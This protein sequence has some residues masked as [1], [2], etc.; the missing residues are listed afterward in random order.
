MR[1][2]S[3][4]LIA[5]TLAYLCVI[6]FGEARTAMAAENPDQSRVVMLFGGLVLVG[7]VTGGVIVVVFLP[8]FGDWVGDFFFNPNQQAEKAPHADALAAIAR[9]DYEQAIAEYRKCVERDGTD[10]H[11]VSEIVRLYCDK[12]GD[13]VSAESV[14]EE[15]LAQDRTHEDAAFLSNRLA[16]VYW[17]HQHD[18]R[19]A[20][21]L[22]LQVV[23]TFPN[24]KHSANAQH[25]LQEIERQLATED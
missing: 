15:A 1:T 21:E 18:A 14:L 5:A 13:P 23:E 9:G 10:T 3:G 11:A 24:T 7:L 8:A 22:L 6:L 25:R 2:L 20:R 19:R 16:E 4:M 12:L 17:N